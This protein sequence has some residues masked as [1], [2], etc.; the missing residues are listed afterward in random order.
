MNGIRQGNNDE[1]G[2]TD[3]DD[4]WTEINMPGDNNKNKIYS[5]MNADGL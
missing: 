4:D 2:N 5:G 3:S 1:S